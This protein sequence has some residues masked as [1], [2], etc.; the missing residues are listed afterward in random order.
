MKKLEERPDYIRYE[1][2]DDI[3]EIRPCAW[4]LVIREKD[5]GEVFDDEFDTREEAKKAMD[6]EIAKVAEEQQ[7]DEV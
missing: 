2:D 1:D 3:I 6:E 4:E 7:Q 5:S